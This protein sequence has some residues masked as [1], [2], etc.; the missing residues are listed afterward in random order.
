MKNPE[1]K[2]YFL[3]MVAL[4]FSVAVF[5]GNGL[6]TE[7]DLFAEIDSITGVTHLKQEIDQVPAA[8]TIIDR[9]T[10][11]SSTAVDLVDLFRL[12]PGFQVYYLHYPLELKLLI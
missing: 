9:R 7:D 4:F 12:V 6:I 3:V 11:E 8:V 5:A 2:T 10:I 1:L